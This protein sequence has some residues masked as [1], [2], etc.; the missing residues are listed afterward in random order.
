MSASTLEVVQQ[1]DRTL[2]T[3][4]LNAAEADLK[5]TA[6]HRLGFALL[7]NNNDGPG[8]VGWLEWGGGIGANKNP[9]EYNELVLGE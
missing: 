6:G 7:V 3:L 8:R 2:Y 9:T 4:K 1:G 5:L